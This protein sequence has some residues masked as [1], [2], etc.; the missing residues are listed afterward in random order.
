MT[1]CI[2]ITEK[3][4][5]SPVIAV[6]LMIAIAVAISVTIYAWSSGFVSQRS[7]QEAISAEYLNLEFM[8]LSGTSLTVYIRSHE[9]SSVYLDA[10]YVNGELRAKN[11]GKKLVGDSVTS[12]DLTSLVNSKGGDGTFQDG[13]EVK[14]VTT[15]GTQIQFKVED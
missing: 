9:P 5:T 13:N 14:L 2:W 3:K 8:R 1:T 7:T 4:G 10:V 15:R 12:V 6:V 11:I